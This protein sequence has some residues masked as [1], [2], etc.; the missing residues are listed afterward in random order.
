MIDLDNEPPR[1]SREARARVKEWVFSALALD[2]DTVAVMVT[3]LTCLEPGCPP[4]ETVIAVMDGVRPPW[5]YKLHK[6]ADQV[7][8]CEVIH[9]A[10]RWDENA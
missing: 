6:R 5:Q 7:A 4:L 8:W 10:N 9:M 2:R 1:S 3:E